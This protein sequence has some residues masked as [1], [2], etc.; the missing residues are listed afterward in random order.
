MPAQ[1][2]LSPAGKRVMKAV[3][4]VKEAL[5]TVKNGEFSLDA[6]GTLLEAPAAATR[7]IES[8]MGGIAAAGGPA[9]LL[10]QIADAAKEIEEWKDDP[11]I[12]PIVQENVTTVIW[13]IF[14]D[15]LEE[16][17]LS[18]ANLQDLIN[19]IADGTIDAELFCNI[20][21]NLITDPVSGIVTELPMGLMGTDD[22]LKDIIEQGIFPKAE[23]FISAFKMKSRELNGP[24][25]ISRALE[26][27]TKTF[28]IPGAPGH[29]EDVT[30]SASKAKQEIGRLLEANGFV[31]TV[32]EWLEG[33]TLAEVNSWLRAAISSQIDE[34]EK[35][36]T[37]GSDDPGE[38]EEKSLLE[39]IEDAIKYGYLPDDEEISKYAGTE[40]FGASL[41]PGMELPDP[42]IVR[43]VKYGTTRGNKY[44]DYGREVPDYPENTYWGTER[45]WWPGWYQIR[46]GT[47]AYKDF[48][49]GYS[50]C[51]SAP[52][53]ITNDFGYVARGFHFE[54]GS[55]LIWFSLTPGGP[56]VNDPDYAAYKLN[57]LSPKRIADLNE[58]AARGDYSAWRRGIR[59]IGTSDEHAGRANWRHRDLT[60]ED[61]DGTPWD[62]GLPLLVGKT[63]F[64]NL[65]WHSYNLGYAGFAL[66]APPEGLGHP[67]LWRGGGWGYGG[68]F[69]RRS[70]LRDTAKLIVTDQLERQESQEENYP[71]TWVNFEVPTNK[72]TQVV[73]P[74]II[75]EGSTGG[76]IRWY[77]PKIT[78][79]GVA[80]SQDPLCRNLALISKSVKE[81]RGLF[82]TYNSGNR[83]AWNE[84]GVS[85][86][87]GGPYKR[88]EWKLPF[89]LYWEDVDTDRPY[90]KMTYYVSDNP[91]WVYRQR[92]YATFDPGPKQ[93]YLFFNWPGVNS[94]FLGEIGNIYFEV[95]RDEVWTPLPELE[96]IE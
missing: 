41:P 79:S 37:D 20:M 90:M 58:Q 56:P 50:P 12:G 75:S 23:E 84:V 39:L 10:D 89:D 80:V 82:P 64:I 68:D 62:N 13:G 71:A 7:A 27:G 25:L 3:E 81:G 60:D 44:D 26:Y 87:I 38:E 74:F 8:A 11:I 94:H 92:K 40:L 22:D 96:D 45:R 83:L 6:L 52:I 14:G 63:Y 32:D 73:I 66:P 15:A 46:P 2:G 86:T 49:L 93:M 70:R 42:S 21:P 88:S 65:W 53:K 9:N 47:D 43:I 5:D 91:D 30:A 54:F 48:G 78:Q 67:P 19:T 57:N 36:T 4:T 31:E 72:H 16:Y 69:W 59:W 17:G 51:Y 34:E 76:E 24:Q 85:E 35:E 1:C 61:D 29:P 18:K 33:K 77:L 28:V 95:G 55:P